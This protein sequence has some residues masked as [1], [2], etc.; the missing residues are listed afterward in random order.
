MGAIRSS[1]SCANT[2]AQY[3][4]LKTIADSRTGPEKARLFTLLEGRYRV[5]K[6]CVAEHEHH[7]NLRSLPFNA[8]YFMT[9]RCRGVHAETL[10]RTLLE[11]EGIGTISFGGAYLR[12]AFSIVDETLLP[13]VYRSIYRAAG[14]LAGN[15]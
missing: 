6:Q 2:P 10:R 5:A 8:G 7:P 1:V 13:G 3:I 4:M 11:Q 14:E 12:V 9:F 15:T